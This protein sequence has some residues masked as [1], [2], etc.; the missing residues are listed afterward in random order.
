M[1]IAVLNKDFCKPDKCS[2]FG[3]KPCIKYCPRVRTGDKTIVLSPDE[4]CVII[5]EN[6][7]SGE[8]ICIK[9]CPFNAISIVNLP[10]PLENQ[11]SFRYGK[12]QFSLFRMAIPKKGKVLGLIGQNGIGKSTLLKLL[13][14]ELKINFGRF[15]KEIPDWKEIIEHYKGSELH[16]YFIDLKENKVKIVH[17]PQNITVI[18]KF[19]SGKVI[20]LLSKNDERNQLEDISKRLNLKEILERDISVLSG[21]ELQRVAIA[22]AYIKD[23]DIYLFDEPSS[24]LDV[25]ERI[26]M[27]KLIRTLSGKNKTIIV[28]EHDLAILD[29]L[30]DYV[31]IIYG[32]P[33]VYGI[34]SHPQGVRV[35]VNIYLNG[36]IKDE[37]VRF[38]E[39]PII[40]HERPPQ[41]SLYDTGTITFS[42][43]DINISLGN[44]H[45]IAAGSEIHAGEII[46]IL[47]PNGIGKTTFINAISKIIKTEIENLNKDL[48]DIEKDNFKELK[49]VI[50]PQY[51]KIEKEGL[52]KE[53]IEQIKVAPYLSQSYKKRLIN[54][55]DL[56]YI[57]ER[58]FSELSGGELQRIAI[59]K[60]LSTEADIYLLDEPSAF[61]DV[62]MRLKVAQLLRKSIEE[63]KKSG[64]VVEHDIITQDFIADSILV[65]EGT[66]GLEGKANPPQNLRDGFNLFLK[67]MGI[68]FR[69]DSITK[70][71]RV[72]KQG[73]NKD[74]YQK[75]INEYYYIP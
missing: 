35:G 57:R 63:L 67:M 21:G 40:F 71:P 41:E 65:F 68:T 26:N 7:C 52:V 44:F 24:Y 62:E 33:G 18:P 73:S 5:T 55:L 48:D 37:N 19:I 51:I 22:A 28:V 66:P 46:G 61:L 4:K 14:N 31:S 32:Q 39:E 60:C 58:K 74:L 59:A 11:M 12:D 2:P 42:Y 15:N 9:K 16:Q 47:G 8:G 49:V 6:L 27:A 30:S 17:K 38:R 75:R 56:E 50:K 72:N 25:S 3:E 29:Y 69:R 34:V 23:G 1:R 10:D 53:V 54:N 45:L 43:E 36:Y 13:S 20:D 64:F 70:R